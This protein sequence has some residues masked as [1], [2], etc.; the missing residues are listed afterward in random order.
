MKASNE[1]ED[2]QYDLPMGFPLD[3]MLD[4]MFPVNE[5]ANEKVLLK[6]VNTKYFEECDSTGER[7]VRIETVTHVHF[8]GSDTRHN[9]TKSTTVEYL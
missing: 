2:L 9:P 5:N 7:R 3:K 4:K 6:E 1:K 8:A